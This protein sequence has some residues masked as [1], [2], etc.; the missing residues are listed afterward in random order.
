M[1]KEQENI[2]KKFVIK[3]QQIKVSKP[4]EFPCYNCANKDPQHEDYCEFA[5]DEYNRGESIW[6]CLGAK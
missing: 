4:E 2:C 5:W 1:L 6:D 3:M